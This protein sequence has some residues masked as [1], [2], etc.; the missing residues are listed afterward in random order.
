MDE[1]KIL[2]CADLHIGAELSTL[3]RLADARRAE[4][5]HTLGSITD[6]CK[7]RGCELLLIGGDLFD[8]NF[9]PKETVDTVRAYLA[10]IPET[11]VAIVPGNHDYLSAD[12]P[13]H[14]EWSSNVHI[15]KEAGYFDIKGVRVHGIPFTGAFSRQCTLPKAAPDMLNILL[16][17]ADLNGGPYNP[18][19]PRLLEQT[20]MDYVALGHIHKSTPV[21]KEGYVSYAYPGSPEPLGFDELGSK[22]AFAG[23]VRAGKAELEF[24]PLCSREYN[25]LHVDISA[26]ADNSEALKI[27]A[28]AL[29]A[30]K[31]NLVKLVLDGENDFTLDTEFIASGLEH[32]VYYLKIIDRTRPRENLDLLKK[33]QTLKGI[34]VRR[35]LERITQSEEH[36]KQAL[37]NA[38][39]LGLSAFNAREVGY[40][41]N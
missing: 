30:Q 41:D 10:A 15:F 3:G 24:L 33:E 23:T 1:I 6:E 38:L 21:L 18:I 12:S 14:G 39:R 5:L 17:H 4:L 35:M 37:S 27:S 2:H 25:E 7:K 28:N 19:T 22:G 8:S 36:E 32:S 11:V 26:A 16:L 9:V 34:F 31:D 40:G 20:G 29:K 13:Y